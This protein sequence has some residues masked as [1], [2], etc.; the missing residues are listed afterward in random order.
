MILSDVT[1]AEY[2]NNGNIK[3]FPNFSDSDIRPTGIR[4]HLGSELLVPAESDITV[5]LGVPE[6]INYNKIVI[7][8]EGFILNKG[9]FVL[10]TTY[11]SIMTGN[12]IVCHLEGR[13][14]IAR[15]GLAIHCTS[16]I[17]DNNHD[18]ARSITLELKNIG[19]FNLVIRPGISIGMLI[20]SELTHPIRQ[21]SQSQYRNQ[22]TVVPPKLAFQDKDQ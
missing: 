15:L 3:I 5:D 9:F 22:S 4:L 6:D 17:I 13:S 2:V 21:R 11:E 16:G 14:T 7:P 12:H 10:G 19:N 8:D 1:I 18:E 20:F